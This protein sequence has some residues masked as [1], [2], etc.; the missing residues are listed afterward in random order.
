[1]IGM[2]IVPSPDPEPDMP[3]DIAFFLSKYG[4]YAVNADKVMSPDAQPATTRGIPNHT[5]T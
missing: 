1:M 2:M 3:T 5:H 4:P